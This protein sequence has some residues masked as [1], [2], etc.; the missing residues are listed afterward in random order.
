MRICIIFPVL[1][2][3][4]E[5]EGCGEQ[6]MYNKLKKK[7]TQNICWKAQRNCKL[8]IIQFSY[9]GNMIQYRSHANG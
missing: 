8:M 4:S 7:C 6:G 3:Q 5:Q 1:L 9:T 2:G